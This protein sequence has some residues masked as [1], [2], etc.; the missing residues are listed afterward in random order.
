[1]RTAALAACLAAAMT[2]PP[3]G[4]SQAPTVPDAVVQAENAEV[5]FYPPPVGPSSRRT[6]P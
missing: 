3:P 4:Q 5:S 6:S 1:M 2:L